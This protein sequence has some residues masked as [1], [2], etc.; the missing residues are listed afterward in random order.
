VRAP[1]WRGRVCVCVCVCV[2]VCVCVCVL[3]QL[4]ASPCPSIIHITANVRARMN[5]RNL[6]SMRSQIDGA[7]ITIHERSRTDLHEYGSCIQCRTEE[8][9]WLLS[10][11]NHKNEVRKTLVITNKRITC[12]PSENVSRLG[13]TFPPFIQPDRSWQCS[14]KL[15]LSWATSTQSTSSETIL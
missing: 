10:Y 5:Y 14:K 1:S 15:S 12:S 13:N 9:F 8:R 2:R 11:T 4:L 3:H 7:E 6:C